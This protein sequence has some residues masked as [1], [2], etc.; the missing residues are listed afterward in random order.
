LYSENIEKLVIIDITPRTYD[1][2]Q[3][4]TIEQGIPFEFEDNESAVDWIS[5]RYPDTPRAFWYGNLDNLFFREENG[6]WSMSSHPSRKTRIML[7]GDGWS[8]FKN[9]SVPTLVLRGSEGV[10][11][12]EEVD[13]MK[14]IMGNLVVKTILGADHLVP[15]T[16]AE[17]FEKAVQ[18]FIPS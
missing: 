1:K 15:F 18:D 16:H 7:D 14:A 10:A 12:V 4:V 17:Q 11:V 6:S 13:K 8:C 5:E 3:Q 9:I 2:P